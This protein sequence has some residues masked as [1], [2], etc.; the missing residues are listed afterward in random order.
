MLY[1]LA[2]SVDSIRADIR[3]EACHPSPKIE[4]VKGSNFAGER[5]SLL[6]KRIILL[7]WVV[8]HLAIH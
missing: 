5:R 7:S 2:L 8:S 3:Y 1:C 4:G 6:F